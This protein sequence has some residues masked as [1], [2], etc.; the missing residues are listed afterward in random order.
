MAGS[1]VFAIDELGV[2]KADILHDATEGHFTHLDGQM[3][4]GPLF[5]SGKIFTCF[6]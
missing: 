3:D 1:L 2:A 4:M 6:S 5:P